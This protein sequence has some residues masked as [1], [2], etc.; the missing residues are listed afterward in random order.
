MP[1][2]EQKGMLGHVAHGH[3]CVGHS[4]LRACKGSEAESRNNC[5]KQAWG[6]AA[7]WAWSCFSC[8]F[9]EEGLRVCRGV[10][11]LRLAFHSKSWGTPGVDGSLRIFSR[12]LDSKAT[13][14]V[15][16][17]HHHD[18]HIPA[19]SQCFL[20]ASMWT[21]LSPFWLKLGD[22][23]GNS[24]LSHD[25]VHRREVWITLVSDSLLLSKVKH[26]PPAPPQKKT[27]SLT[28]A[29]D[30]G[31]IPRSG[32]S[33]GEG[34]GN[35]LQYPCLENSMNRRAW[36]ATVHGVTKSWTWLSN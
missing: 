18:Q 8:G 2:V 31:L 6:E 21:T 33:P 34:T 29:G 11:G 9:T 3:S 24:L 14:P 1:Q 28:A 5:G 32:R 26:R 35:P 20:V 30:P 12:P 10:L 19:S 15:L 23:T 22:K 17:C 7:L 36:W 16:F 25:H 4:S 13:I 27:T